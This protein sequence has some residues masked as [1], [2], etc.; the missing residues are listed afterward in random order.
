MRVVIKR[1]S[2]YVFWAVSSSDLS[3]N[4]GI[5]VQLHHLVLF[6]KS[7]ISVP[8]IR[9]FY[10]LSILGRRVESTQIQGNLEFECT[11]RQ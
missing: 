3:P 4:K 5:P 2:A 10:L 7:G 11:C 1:K 6:D 9:S 8:M